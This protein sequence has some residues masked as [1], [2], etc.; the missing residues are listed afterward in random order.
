MRPVHRLLIAGATV[1]AM[2]AF[3]AASAFAQSV[4]VVDEAT[5]AHCGDIALAA[6][7]DVSGGCEIHITNDAL[8]VTT[9]HFGGSGE[10]VTSTCANNFVANINEFGIG[11]IDV[12]TNT[13]VENEGA[14]CVAEACDEP[15]TGVT[16][17]A[18]LEW[19]IGGINEYG[20]GR[21]VMTMSLCLRSHAQAEGTI[22][23]PC[24]VSFDVI[25][26]GHEQEFT[27][28]S[29][30]CLENSDVEIIGHWTSDSEEDEML[31][32]HVHYP[33]DDV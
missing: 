27:V 6:G 26:I 33:G 30:A 9:S 14:G 28:N 20:S 2:M 12:D 15:E 13:I 16:P 25:Q 22:G 19:P 24:T 21:E 4:E 8:T 29:E 23:V 5:D 11:Y 31:V 7:H 3:L 18:G 10:I 1:L 32:N 17:H